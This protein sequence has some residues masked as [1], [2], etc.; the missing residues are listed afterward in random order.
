MTQEGETD[1]YKV[2]HHIK[3]IF[4]HGGNGI[5]DYVATNTKDINNIMMEKYLE[6]NC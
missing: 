5:I 6:K 3:A 4:K 1:N 2:S